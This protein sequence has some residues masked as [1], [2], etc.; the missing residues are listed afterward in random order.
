MRERLA[1]RGVAVRADI[2]FGDDIAEGAVEL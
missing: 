2:G 1:R